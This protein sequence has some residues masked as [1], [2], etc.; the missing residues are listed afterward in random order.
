MSG[1]KGSHLLVFRRS[2]FIEIGLYLMAVLAVDYFAFS[3]NRFWDVSPHPFWGIVLLIAVQYGTSEALLAAGA[4]SVALLAGNIPA[5]TVVQDTYDYLFTITKDPLIW[6]TTA[7]VLGEIR[8]R[9]VRERIQ[10]ETAL[11]DSIRRMSQF[12]TA[13]DRLSTLRINLERRIAGQFRTAINVYRAARTLDR[14]DPSEV[15]MGVVDIVNAVMNPQKFSLYLLSEDALEI[16]L[17]HGWQTADTYSRNFRSNSS[18]FTEVIGHQRVLCVANPADET[19]LAGEGVLAGP[20]VDDQTGDIVG[21]LKIEQLSFL[22]LHFSNVQ[23]FKAVCEWIAHSYLNARNLQAAQAEA[24][25]NTRTRIMTH[26]FFERQ[27]DFLIKLGQR[28]GFEISMIVIRLENAD[29]VGDARASAIPVV[30]NSISQGILRSTDLLFEHQA[31]YQYCVMLPNTPAENAHKVVA[32]LKERLSEE[33]RESLA[34]A[35]F[36]M[37]V[38]NVYQMQNEKNILENHI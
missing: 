14:T 9:H 28:V 38:Q 7:I 13:C 16:S 32:K 11:D 37:T 2:A 22:D 26:T 10:L 29:E 33:T 35:R 5:Q 20:L 25:I 3:G 4:A 21:M 30:L 31:G 27:R 1:T 23:T 36:S 6:T 15:L 8:M 17:E 18:L 34:D 19:L 24:L 12:E